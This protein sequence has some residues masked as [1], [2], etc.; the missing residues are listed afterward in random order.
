MIGNNGAH[1]TS[2]SVTRNMWNRIKKIID[3]HN[4]TPYVGRHTYATNMN[5]AGISLRTAMAIM[6]HKDE[7]MLLRTYT[8][9]DNKDLTDAG[10]TMTRYLAK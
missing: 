8:H 4:M 3:I 9:V 10:N 7:R 1:V 2:E 6:G 5:R